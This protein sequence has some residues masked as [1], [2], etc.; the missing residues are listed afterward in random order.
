M[1]FQESHYAGVARSNRAW[2]MEVLHSGFYFSFLRKKQ[3]SEPD[4]RV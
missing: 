2:V 1:G 4:L 3:H